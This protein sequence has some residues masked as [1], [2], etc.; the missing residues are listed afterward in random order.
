MKG[1][2]RKLDYPLLIVTIILSLFGLVMIFS[3]SSI[4]SVLLYKSSEYYFFIK[5][6]IVLGISLPISLIIMKIPTK[7]YRYL[8]RFMILG[9]IGLLILLR[10]Y[11]TITNS[12]QSWFRILGFSVQPSEFAKTAI[13]LYLAAWY[14]NRK[15]FNTIYDFFIP[16]IGCVV[17]FFL[18]ALEPD[19]GTAAIIALICMFIVFT[20][21]LDKNKIMQLLKTLVLVGLIVAVIG[22]TFGMNFLTET[23][24]SRF[25]FLN[26]CDRYLEESGYQVCNGY[27][28]MNN[29]GLLGNGLGKSTQKYLY[30]PAAHTDFIF[31]IIVEELGLVGGAVVIILYIFLLYRILTIARNAKSLSGSIIAFGTFSYVLIHIMINLGGVLALIPLTG[32]PLPFLSYGGT[33]ILNLSILL[34]LTQRV[35]I[36]S[37]ETTIKMI[38][39]KE[40]VRI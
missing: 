34:A 10:T 12:A 4:T 29:G 14:G 17:I 33:F 26:P 18:V 9:I 1:S 23:Q 22:I 37:K 16:L 11:G 35:A 25:N 5:Q 13:I 2:Y 3:A 20:L 28:A 40:K 8:S 30:L 6:A 21:P 19:L 39:K 32:V 27:I 24:K 15:K 38:N 36:E 31:P 7:V